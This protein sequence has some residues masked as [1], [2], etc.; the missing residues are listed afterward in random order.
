MNNKMKPIRPLLL[1]SLLLLGAC[2]TMHDDGAPP[3]DVTGAEVVTKKADNG[4][5]VSEYRIGGQVKMV[6]V[7]PPRGPA[8]YLYDHGD[9]AL[10]PDGDRQMPQTHWKL[11]SW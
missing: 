1:S 6:K 11:F 8:Y 10:K 9:G 4:D 5:V 7:Q 2:A 3:V